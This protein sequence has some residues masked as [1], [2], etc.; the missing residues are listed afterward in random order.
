MLIE[1]IISKQKGRGGSYI[2]IM[3]T[4]NLTDGYREK[5]LRKQLVEV[6]KEKGITSPEV[7]AAIGAIPRHLFVDS[8]FKELAYKDM[9]LRIA[10]GQT[11]SQPYTVAYQTELLQV[12]KGEKVLEIG[13]GSGYQAAVLVQCGVKLYTIERQKILYEQTKIFLP[14]LGYQPRFFYGDGYKGL[15]SYAPFHKII[16]TAGAPFIPDALVSQLMPGGRLVIPVGEGDSQIMH[17]IT[18]DNEGNVTTTTTGE[19]RF[20]PMLK[21]KQ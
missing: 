1:I 7:L 3:L 2:C 10:A 13:T 11:I 12:Q 5:G 15:A 4:Q 8:A 18:K 20:V 21:E 9:A 19:F 16:V 6:L 14:R 17:L